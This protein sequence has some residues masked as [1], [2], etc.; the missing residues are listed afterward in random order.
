M[1]ALNI[2]LYAFPAAL[3][4][5]AHAGIT[6]NTFASLLSERD[7]LSRHT[8]SSSSVLVFWLFGEGKSR[9]GGPALLFPFPHL[10]IFS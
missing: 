9:P 2:G 3:L 1:H 8:F 6:A 5:D 7:D 10:L 4:N